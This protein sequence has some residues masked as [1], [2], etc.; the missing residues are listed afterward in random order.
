MMEINNKISDAI[1]ATLL[2]TGANGQLGSEL[3]QA[4]NSLFCAKGVAQPNLILT[5]HLELDITNREALISFVKGRQIDI[6]I[7]C[8]AFTAVDRAEEEQEAARRL[9]SDGVA[10]LAA[11]AIECD[12]L[13]FHISTDYVFDGKSSTPYK[14]EAPVAPQSV[15]GATK[16]EGERA[17]IESKAKYLLIRTSWLYS[18][19]GNN[20]VK[21]ITA[22]AKER[23]SL[24]VVFDQIGTPTYATD[25]ANAI[26]E[27]SLYYLKSVKSRE[28]FPFGIYHFSNEGVCSWYDFA[29]EIVKF[30]GANCEVKAVTSDKFITKAKRPSYSVFDKSKIKSTFN[31][32]I[33][34][35]RDS[36]ELYFIHYQNHTPKE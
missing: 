7:N 12:A 36:L 16:A 23:D 13:L 20:F 9:N 10:N 4:A 1:S 11:A 19:F 28:S 22:L 27:I 15:Y 21:T 3:K 35:W 26:L 2:I 25:L 32:E 6:I 18:I 8:A 31:I 29:V 5:D 14:E 24:N 33:S 17:L 30:S 34:H